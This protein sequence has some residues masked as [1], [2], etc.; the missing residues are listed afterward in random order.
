M[1]HYES[2]E[3][4]GDIRLMLGLIYSRYLHQDQLA[5]TY[6]SRAIAGLADAGKAQLASS[7]LEK[8]RQRLR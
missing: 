7:E 8:V 6:L 1:R 3:Y 2:Y 4:I 5:E